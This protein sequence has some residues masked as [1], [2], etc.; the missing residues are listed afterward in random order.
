M[1]AP[2][3]GTVSRESAENSDDP[4]LRFL[5]G[6]GEMG[7]RIRG[8][9]WQQAGLGQP[10]LWPASLKTAVGIMLHS[11][12]PIYIA[13]GPRF[14][15]LYNDAYRPILG[16]LKHPAALG[17]TTPGTWPEIWDFIGPMFEGVVSSGHAVSMENQLLLMLRNGY[18]EECFFNF[19]Y[20]PLTD[21][22]GDIRGVIVTALEITEKVVDARRTACI[23][24]L[25]EGLADAADSAQVGSVMA[26]LVAGCGTDLPFGLLYSAQRDSACIDLEA[27]FGIAAGTALSPAV[28]DPREAG[29]YCGC[30]DP[31]AATV[32]AVAP[33]DATAGAALAHE[34][35]IH[36]L[37]YADHQRPAG[38]LMLA[39]NPRR[40]HDDAQKAFLKEIAS[41][42]EQALRRVTRRDL[43][44]REEQHRYQSIMD[45]MPYLVWMSNE[46]NE[47]DFFNQAW[48]VFRGRTHRQETGGWSGGIHPD[49]LDG[50]VRNFDNALLTHDAFTIEYRLLRADGAY[51]W[52]LDRSSPRHSIAGVFTGYIG[53]CLDITERKQ[54]ELRLHNLAQARLEE[55]TRQ[56]AV[57]NA[58]PAH[59][60]LLDAQGRIMEVN[61]AWRRFGHTAGSGDPLHGVG[62]DYVAFCRGEAGGAGSSLQRVAAG[63]GSVLSGAAST[64]S[65][66][67]PSGAGDALRWFQLTVVPVLPQRPH[68][69]VVMYLDVTA[70]RQASV[71]LSA[72]EARF[73]QMAESIRDVFFLHE[74][75]G[76]RMLY[77]SPA[78]EEMWGRSC[79]GLYAQPDSWAAAIHPQERASVRERYA[80]GMAHGNFDLEFRIVRPDD[81]IRHIEIRV[82]PVRDGDGR[83]VRAA[84]VAK[85]VTH[86][87]LAIQAL[88]ASE[89]RFR[90]MLEDV[91]MASLMLDRD[92]RVTFCNGYLLAL[93][94][95][96][97]EEVIGR[98]WFE[99]FMVPGVYQLDDGF[100]AILDARP[101]TWFGENEVVTRSGQRRLVRW[102]NSLLR[103]AGGD[104]VGTA[105]I[106]E[107]ITDNKRAEQEILRLNASLEQRVIDRTADLEQARNDAN[108]ANQAKSSFLASMSHEI[109]T[110]MNGVIGMI[111][112]LHR[113]RLD[114]QQGEMVALVR[115]SA[116]SL[117]AILDDILDFSKIEAGRIELECAPLSIADVVETACGIMDH[118]ASSKA[119]EF[120]LF[121]DPAIPATVL[122]DEQRL[123]QV[124]LNL[125]NNAIKFSSGAGR[126]GQ[127]AVRATLG[128][129]DGAQAMV[130]IDVADNGPGIDE[131][132]QARLFTAFAQADASTTRRFGGT[133]LGL[134]I[135]RNLAQ[136]MG[137]AVTFDTTPG[138]GSTFTVCLPFALP[139][140][141]TPA[142]GQSALAGL[143]CV[144]VGPAHA[145][146]DDVAAYLAADG[147][148]VERAADLAQVHALMVALPPGQW[149]WIIDSATT[150][151]PLVQWRDLAACLPA[152]RIGMVG[153]GRAARWASYTLEDG[154]VLI[155][156][157]VLTRKR[158]ARAV[159]LAAGRV[160][161]DAAAAPAR[162]QPAALQAPSREAAR[163]AG[164]LLLVAEDNETNQKVISLQLGLLGFAADIAA[165]GR[166][167]L[168]LWRGGGHAM[169]LCDL[170]MPAMDG[171]A[172]TGAIRAAE[173]GTRRLPI[174]ALTANTLPGESER[175][176]AAGMDDY[177]SK[178]LQL[179]ELR[180]TLDRW[181]PQLAGGDP[182]SAAA[183][184]VDI[185]VLERLIG[186][187]RAIIV[188]FLGDFRGSA[189]RIGAL[190][191]AACRD[192]DQQLACAQAHQLKS[193]AWTVGA[194]AL[195]DLC[196]RIEGAATA[197]SQQALLPLLE[198]ELGA[199]MAFLDA[200]DRSDAGRTGR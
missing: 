179:A 87:K 14:V 195:G 35:S 144:V 127:V 63:V 77:I 124:L 158:L 5:R 13:W 181:L 95:W 89:K 93:T 193:S 121:I 147:A 141:A 133:G 51:R 166:Q 7:A 192:G 23:R 18:P 145:P 26:A 106:G 48:L 17:G 68:G 162:A 138:H 104:V 151:S 148:R 46:R 78:Y 135:S 183:P 122:G 96:T 109:R 149:I 164:R 126:T 72:S 169:L 71:R 69:V 74:A 146:A 112:V 37:C 50:V 99:M 79:A 31:A 11:A 58:L 38:Y 118:M 152:H 119:V 10:S 197:S 82:F 176:R 47:C 128:P 139:Q 73:R 94:G 140:D 56:A 143:G 178:P 163:R 80:H 36:P 52:M 91:G 190:L 8:Q 187:D 70:E 186:N 189:R 90:T 4:S 115:E 28:L 175:C 54:G 75:D 9:D 49:D 191:T 173:Q 153:I 155:D 132:A 43:E 88:L 59:I 142:R 53:T 125:I 103:G 167:A 123:R 165:D 86:R 100:A 180:A 196:A 130:R 84:G 160:A 40:P 1:S 150:A 184:A 32:A 15:Q 105:S 156:G 161:A 45:A 66:V 200:P 110:P 30:L 194:L 67:Y 120:T 107:D 16:G 159:A 174:V 177:L 102:N 42:V 60:A 129:S 131:G 34:V 137:G 185:G 114:E 20:S 25:V 168:A 21:E 116:L 157:N 41:Q 27:A 182:G 55:T 113:T 154:L 22:L 19:S 108:T 33:G 76:A 64:F 62:R 134:V 3:G 198:R 12:A 101:E 136:L 92:A 24:R 170:H 172:L 199:V 6:G 188:E 39:V 2:A 61:E 81:S 97:H 171:Y 85:D 57:L 65:L 117:L 44:R 98:N 29:P 111:D 83:I